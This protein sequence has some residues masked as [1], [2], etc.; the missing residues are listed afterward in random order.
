MAVYARELIAEMEEVHRNPVAA[1]IEQVLNHRAAT[2]LVRKH[3]EQ[4][5]REVFTALAE[6][7]NFPPGR[8]LW[9]AMQPL[10]PLH[11]FVRTRHAPI[12]RVRRIE[13]QPWIV[14][15]EV[16][17]SATEG[18]ATQRDEFLLR[19]NERGSLLVIRRRSIG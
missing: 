14:S 11:C 17:H 9:N 15:V 4:L 6:V 18:S 1:Y 19:R 2:K 16:E 10:V 13:S 12:F 7:H 3:G 8:R 5:V